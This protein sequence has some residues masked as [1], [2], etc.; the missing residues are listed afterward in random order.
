[1]L[2]MEPTWVPNP[3]NFS[4]SGGLLNYQW[5]DTLLQMDLEEMNLTMDQQAP[6]PAQVASLPFFVI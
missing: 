3:E 1:M 6:Q 2:K 4:P 5:T